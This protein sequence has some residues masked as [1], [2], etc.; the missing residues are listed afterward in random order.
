MGDLWGKGSRNTRVY[1]T[2]LQEVPLTSTADEPFADCHAESVGFP[3]DWEQQK[4]FEK[5]ADMIMTTH[6]AL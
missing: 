1:P 3:N 5:R 6:P 4:F 2:P